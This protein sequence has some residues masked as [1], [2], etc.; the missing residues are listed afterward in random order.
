MQADHSKTKIW[1]QELK[2]YFALIGKITSDYTAFRI[3]H[4]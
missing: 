2:N 4:K 3:F 1:E